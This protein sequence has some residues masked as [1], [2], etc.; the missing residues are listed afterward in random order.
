[1]QGNHSFEEKIFI[2]SLDYLIRINSDRAG[3]LTRIDERRMNEFLRHRASFRRLE[4]HSKVEF[5]L[6]GYIFKG[7]IQS[8]LS[9]HT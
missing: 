3:P 5:P 4:E 8:C 6:G 7:E 1:M 2:N 9:E